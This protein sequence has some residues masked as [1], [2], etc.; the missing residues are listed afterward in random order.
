M[1]GKVFTAPICVVM[2]GTVAV[3]QI[4]NVTFTENIDRAKVKGLGDLI[5]TQFPPLSIM[6]S[7][8][9]SVNSVNFRT[10]GIPSSLKRA[11]GTAQRLAD[12]ITLAEEPVTITIYRREIEVLNPKTGIVEESKLVEF[13]TIKDFYLESES[14]E[15][16]NESIATKTQTFVYSTPIFYGATAF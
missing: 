4:Q 2:V 8:S 3:A 16:S 11:S 9:F 12:T 1:A 7:G 14:F 5:Y 13:A 6:C 10:D 15:M